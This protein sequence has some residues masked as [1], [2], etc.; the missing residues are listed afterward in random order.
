MLQA[1]L[2]SGRF[3]ETDLDLLGLVDENDADVDDGYDVDLAALHAEISAS[4][5]AVRNAQAQRTEIWKNQ[6]AKSSDDL[7][8][9]DIVLLEIGIRDRGVLD[10]PFLPAVVVTKDE[11]GSMRLGG[12]IAGPLK[13]R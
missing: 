6:A 11:H 12:Q 2:E 1:M 4:E 8:V 7:E 5:E 10:P 3:N 9:G 13:G